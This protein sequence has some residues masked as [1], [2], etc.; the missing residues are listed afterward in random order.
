MRR[1]AKES[2]GDETSGVIFPHCHKR[3]RPL[4]VPISGV[5]DLP[6]GFFLPFSSYPNV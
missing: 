6:D 2:H 4:F 3:D 1:E 5:F